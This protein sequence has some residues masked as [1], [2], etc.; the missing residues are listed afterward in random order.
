[1]LLELDF[2]RATALPRETQTKHLSFI[3]C[4]VSLNTS[5]A[6]SHCALLIF[7]FMS[8]GK[9][10][11]GDKD[12]PLSFQLKKKK[13]YRSKIRQSH[14]NEC[15]P[16]GIYVPLLVHE[17]QVRSPAYVNDSPT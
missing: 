4:T 6:Q 7:P 14:C 17:E 10:I 13:L 11:V 1:M 15:D 2:C 9:L 8:Q 12:V 16:G 5:L 3:Y